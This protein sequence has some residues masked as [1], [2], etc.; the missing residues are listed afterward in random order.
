MYV[1]MCAH[2]VPSPVECGDSGVGLQSFRQVHGPFGV[3]VV[4]SKVQGRQ[5]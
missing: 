5:S 1:Y 3:D 2:F 4:V